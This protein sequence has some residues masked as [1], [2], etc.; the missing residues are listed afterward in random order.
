[1]EDFSGDFEASS[2]AATNGSFPD[3]TRAEGERAGRDSATGISLAA[4]DLGSNSFHLVIAKAGRHDVRIVDRLREPVRLAGGL[5]DGGMLSDESQRRAL[6]CLSRFAERLHPLSPSCVRAVGTNTLR[7]ARNGRE[8]LARAQE[9]LGHRIEVISGREEARLVYLGVAHHAPAETARRLVVDIGG[10]STE[11]ITGEGFENLEAHSLFVGCVGLSQRFFEGGVVTRDRFRAAE[12][13][14]RL[15]LRTIERVIRTRGWEVCLGAA[16]TVASVAGIL[17]EQGWTRGGVTPRG[18]AKLRRALVRAG[19]VEAAR[20]AG[21]REDRAPVLAGGLAILIGVFESLGVEEMLESPGALREGVIYDL[22]GRIRHEDVRDRT[23]RR[24][25]D[26]YHADLEQAARVERTAVHLFRKSSFGRSPEA[27]SVERLLRWAARI[28]EI[29]LAV[30]YAGYHRHGA[31]LVA[32]SDMPG[33]SSD[34]Q[35]L[36]AALVRGHRRRFSRSIFADL[37]KDRVETAWRLTILLRLAV[38]LNRSRVADPTPGVSVAKDWAKI[39]LEFPPG[40]LGRHPMTA[41]DLEH[42]AASLA[43]AAVELIVRES[44][45]RPAPSTV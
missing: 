23:I 15:E 24:F 30:A 26:R 17:R 32:N 22:L 4:V 34:E 20:L 28:H 36:L 6:A 10:G 44:P 9:I 2:S 25:V 33:F 14:A 38:L 16:G 43:P 8:F 37:P 7:R 19:S 12:T 11:I 42:E 35:R 31:Y 3:R 1:M 45:A 21:L 27:R 13:E 18:L 40:W 5:D 39:V 29:G 41:A